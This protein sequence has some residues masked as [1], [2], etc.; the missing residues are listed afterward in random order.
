MNFAFK[1]LN[2]FELYCTF[3]STTKS[4]C[5]P[6]TTHFNRPSAFSTRLRFISAHLL[7]NR[8][9]NW[10]PYQ[11]QNIVFWCSVPIWHSRVIIT[12]LMWPLVTNQ[13]I[14]AQIQNHF[15]A[16][17]ILMSRFGY[18]YY[19]YLHL[20]HKFMSFVNRPPD[21]KVM[22]NFGSRVLMVSAQSFAAT[23]TS[24]WL[25]AS[26]KGIHFNNPMPRHS[27]K[28]FSHLLCPVE[29]GWNKFHLSIWPSAIQSK[30][31]QS[32]CVRKSHK[33]LILYTP[34][35]NLISVT[36]SQWMG[37]ENPK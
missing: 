24:F 29:V 28:N 3:S 18:D 16:Q 31:F 26:D 23:Q 33:S 15:S 20:I 13:R 34:T 32:H 37:F 6:T 27:P 4:G 11:F 2:N 22:T 10:A 7:V 19:E 5:L 21:I 8:M 30:Y 1:P 12:L 17:H 25:V 14:R 36:T 35:P 9:S